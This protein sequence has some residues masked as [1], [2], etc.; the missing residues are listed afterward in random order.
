M[1]TFDHHNAWADLRMGQEVAPE[2]TLAA[3]PVF[4]TRAGRLEAFMG[5]G[6]RPA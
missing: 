4:E 1:V 2:G 3:M 6:E 5:I